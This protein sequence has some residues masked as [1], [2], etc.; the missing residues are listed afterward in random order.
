MTENEKAAAAAQHAMAK[1]IKQ[2]KWPEMDADALPS[3]YMNK[4]LAC[5]GSWQL[6]LTDLGKALV[7]MD[8]DQEDEVVSEFLDYCI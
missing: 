7:S 3:C 8:L 5:V 2:V 1:Q 6:R 4:V